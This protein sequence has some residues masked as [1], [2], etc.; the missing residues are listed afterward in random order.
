MA[1]SA[2]R[3]ESDEKLKRKPKKTSEDFRRRII[4]LS[5]KVLCSDFTLCAM[6]SALCVFH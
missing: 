5:E 3:K 1:Q 6:L 4:V 2:E